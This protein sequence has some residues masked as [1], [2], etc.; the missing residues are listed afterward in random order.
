MLRIGGKQ[1]GHKPGRAGLHTSSAVDAGRRLSY[2]I[3][4][5]TQQ[6]GRRFRCGHI[7]IENA[8]AHHGAARHNLLR[9]F[10]KAARFFYQFMIIRSDPD[11]K[12][13]GIG[14]GIPRDGNNTVH[15]RLALP[16]RTVDRDHGVHIVHD[17]SLI[18]IWS[19]APAF[20]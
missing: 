16:H 3:L 8:E 6:R 15:Q 2:L 1:C 20:R 12:I 14:N 4:R 17:L 19:A 7:Q 13:L 11:N 18:H 5:H 10:G 9:L